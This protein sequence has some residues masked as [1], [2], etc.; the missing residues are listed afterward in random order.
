MERMKMWFSSLGKK[1]E[2]LG[3][4]FFNEPNTSRAEKIPVGVECILMW[5]ALTVVQTRFEGQLWKPS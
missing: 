4:Y 2:N 5:A 3:S 1:V